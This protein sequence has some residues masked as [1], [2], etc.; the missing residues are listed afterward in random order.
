MALEDVEFGRKDEEA[1]AVAEAVADAEA[2]GTS[3]PETRCSSFAITCSARPPGVRRR[4]VNGNWFSPAGSER[5]HIA[6]EGSAMRLLCSAL[7]I[8]KTSMWPMC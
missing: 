2:G 7:A 3:R 6:A 8:E 5:V 1:A 4:V